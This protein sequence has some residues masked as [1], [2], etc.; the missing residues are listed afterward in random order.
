MSIVQITS[1]A[2]TSG[3]R[4]APG[5]AYPSLL[6]PF[7]LKG[8]TLRNR[9]MSSAHAP[10]YTD[11]GLPGERYQLYHEEKAKGG[12]ALTLFG[13]SSS[14]A[15]DSSAIYSQIYVGSDRVVPYFRQ[16]AGRVHRHGAALMC[17]ISHMGRRTSWDGGDWFP[18]LAPSVVRDPAHHSVPRAI[19]TR[20][21][22]RII[23]AFGDAAVRCRDGELDGCEI[24]TTTHLLGQFLSP[25]SNRREDGYGGSLENRARFALEVIEEVRNRVGDGFIVGVR[26]TANESNEDGL[27]AEEGI[28]IGRLLARTGM[29]DFLNVNGRYAGTTVGNSL[30]YPGMESPSA[31]YIMLAKQVREASGLPVFQSARIPDLANAEYSV[32]GGFLDMVGMTRPHIADPHMLAKLARGEEDRIRP[33]VGAN[34]CMDRAFSSR[35]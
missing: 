12:I 11:Q 32:A 9:V 2:Q 15:R 23:K 10:V 20:D 22:A 27:T 5:N 7:R 34:Y 24:L 30:T 29:V 21:I 3:R 4:P 26:F 18:T 28:E 35:D 16:L 17:Q 8:L 14:V 13:G 19:S 31:P 6:S 1:F 33:C 25:L